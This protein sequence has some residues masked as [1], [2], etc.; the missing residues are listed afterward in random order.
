MYN[1]KYFSNFRDLSERRAVEA[2][3]SVLGITNPRLRNHLIQ[4]FKSGKKDSSFLSDPVFEVMFAWESGSV[5]ME[6]LAGGLLLPSIVESMDSADFSKSIYPFKHQL[7]AWET[8]LNEKKSI[9]VTSGTGSGKTECFMVPILNDLAS[10]YE[11]NLEQLVGV[12]ALFIYP[13]N[14]LINSQRERLRAWTSHY[15]DGLRFALYNGNTPEYKHKDQGKFPNEILTRKIL[16]ETP[17]PILVTNATMLEYMLVRQADAPIVEKSQGKLRWIV[18][19]EAHTYLGSQ[20]AEL[21]LLLR[22]VLYTFGVES[23][24][25]RFIATSATIG[26]AEAELNLQNYLANLA[27]ISTEQ[28]KVIGGRRLVPDVASTMPMQSRDIQDLETIEPGVEYSTQ[29]FQALAN[30]TQSL[31]L[32]NKISGSLVPS[33]L[34]S[35]AAHLFGDASKTQQTLAW[36]DLCS[37]TSLPGGNEKKPEKGSTPFL[38]LRGHFLHQVVNGLWCCVNKN[39]SAKIGSDLAEGWAFGN[40]FTRR[41]TIC[42]CGAPVYELVFCNECN[43]PHLLVADHNGRLVQLDHQAIDEFSL[44]FESDETSDD[45]DDIGIDTFEKLV[46]ANRA[47]PQVTYPVSIDSLGNY[48][49]PGMDTYDIS[50]LNPED[51]SCVACGYSQTQRGFYRRALLST[52][53]YISNSMPTLLDACNEGEKPTELPSRGRRLITFTDSRQGTARISTKLQQD[54]ERDSVRGMTYGQCAKNTF[55]ISPA[56][57]E[58]KTSS[59]L[60]AEKAVEKLKSIGQEDLAEGSVE[61]ANRLREELGNIGKAIAV[62]WYDMVNK[63]QSSQDLSRWIFDYYRQLNPA[64]FPESGGARVLAEVMLLREF[65]RRPKRL[66]SLETLGL[67]SVQYPALDAISEIPENWRRLG[68]NL[69]DWKSFLK[70][71]LDFFV[72]ENYIVD[73]P[74]D[75]IDWMGAK[76]YPKTVLK[77][78]SEEVAGSRL[79]RWP[80]VGKGRQGR[81]VRL[82]VASSGLSFD[83]HGDVDLINSIMTSAWGALTKAYNCRD[84]NTGQIRNRQILRNVEGTVTYHLSREEIAFKACTEAWKCPITHRLLDNTFKGITPYLPSNVT[85]NQVICEKVTIPICRIDVAEIGSDTERKAAIR[86]WISEQADITN[87][88]SENLWTDISDKIL[89]GGSFYRVAE[90]SAQQPARKLEQ[91]E[92][93]FKA[94]KLNVLS[95]STTME[96]GVDIGG[97]S[98]VAMNNIPPHPA[99][100]LQRAGR[101]GR[102]GETQALAFSICKDNPHER[103]VFSNPQWPFITAIPA[104]YI[105]LNS[106]RIVQRHINSLLLAYF[107]KNV[108]QVTEREVTSLSCEWFFYAEQGEESPS[109]KMLRWLES[110]QISSVPKVLEGGIHQVIRG[111]AL[112]SISTS[113]IIRRSELS[114]S[115]ARDAWLPGYMKL[116]L[117]LDELAGLSES[118]PYRR[119][120]SFDLKSMGRDYLLSELATRAYLPGYGFPS[121]VVTFDHYSISDFKRGKLVN[122]KG[123]IDNQA[124]MRERPARDL[125]TALREYAPGAQVVLDGR[126]YQSAGILLNKFSPDADFSEPQRMLVEWRCHK[127]GTIGNESGATFERKCSSCGSGLEESNIKEFIEPEGFAVDFYSSPTIDISS[128]AFIPIQEPWVFAGSD[129]NPLFDPRL[130]SYRTSPQGHIFHHS[131]GEHGEGFAVC[132]RCGKAGSMTENGEYPAHLRPGKG[133]IRLQGKPGPESSAECEGSDEAYAIKGSVHLGTTNQTDVFELNLKHVNEGVHIKHV[134]KDPLPWTLAVVFRQALA[135]IQGINADEMGFMV[136][137]TT[138]PSC[139]YPVA[140]IVLYDKSAGGAGF[141]SSAFRYFPEIIKRSLNYLDCPDSCES[142]CQSCLLGY[143][144]RFHTDVMNRHKAAEFVHQL[145]PYLEVPETAKVFGETTKSCF[146][147]L[148]AELVAAASRGATTVSI[149]STGRFE[150]WNIGAS[151]L[152]TTCLNLRG[153]FDTVQLILPSSELSRLSEEHKEDLLALRNFKIDVCQVDRTKLGQAPFENTL[154]QT[155]G[156]GPTTTFGTNGLEANLPG[157]G[158]WNLD[159]QFLV[160]S[161]NID[162]ISTME[163][164]ADELKPK[165]QAGDVEI[166][167]TDDCDGAISQFG[168]RFW[169][170]ILQKSPGM[171]KKLSKGG[172][173]ERVFYSDC[174]ICS[175]WSLM[176][177]GE[178][179]DKLRSAAGDQWDGTRFTLLTS[180]KT[181]NYPTRGYLSEWQDND[182]KKEVCSLYFREMGIPGTTHVKNIKEMPHGRVVK[183]TWS[184]GSTATVRLDHGFG[185]WR[186]DGKPRDWFDINADTSSQVEQMYSA[187][188]HL[189]AKFSKQFPTQIFVKI[190]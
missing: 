118:D 58:E 120:V 27:G 163:I 87:L 121:G 132:L 114:L 35:L 174:Y 70:T 115:N 52:P 91:Y 5:T 74:N 61:L 186:I 37:S 140:S 170:K 124:R 131:S 151:E 32:R 116:K 47:N 122:E 179:I 40:V 135:D 2:T 184:D 6:Q 147:P 154:V 134:N 190:R 125:P 11:E 90:H 53:F 149:V 29:R 143:D 25:V 94:G 62:D 15:D 103:S 148:G 34:S 42:E 79:M 107:L 33:T 1:N 67:V 48:A 144:T 56:Q 59:L 73:I 60:K 113:E 146:E 165:A 23:K 189:K 139:N 12:R 145:L 31:S 16:R 164:N 45:D 84:E 169:T 63:L 72:R 153:L 166:D 187:A 38:P 160:K 99:N 96:M 46:I 136:K 26:D 156:D 77:P 83:N 39:C 95:C 130:G 167:M 101:A 81:M 4:Q 98:V 129:L 109:E 128:Q 66:N 22:R 142:A 181:S 7:A 76:V 171:A 162:K 69:Y 97:I 176:L 18:L 51:Q 152:K 43:S 44:D 54:S 78:A 85:E 57:I 112:A 3:V 138:L 14:A 88:R 104:P 175:P 102:R 133:H 111:S 150:E 30:T 36:I 64:L 20:A 168:T 123:R 68:F 93:L 49:P 28:V 178:T 89:E 141:A 80:K 182:E 108:I 185:C 86:S 71:F 19:D 157:H 106:E 161:E 155:A 117:Q 127:C 110:M 50:I 177:L 41:K 183:L 8:L 75:W 126:C 92:N 158:W 21:S 24:D 100:Y 137:P 172:K 82:L 9:V 173:L 55:W 119:K 65:T 17:A 13:L 188:S 10:E 105:S 180:D 159:G